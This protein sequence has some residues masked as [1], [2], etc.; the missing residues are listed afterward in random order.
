MKA[1]QKGF[2]LMDEISAE[3]DKLCTDENRPAY[4]PFDFFGEG[5]LQALRKYYPQFITRD[6]NEPTSRVPV[7]E[8]VATPEGDKGLGQVKLW[9]K[10]KVA[11]KKKGVYETTHP[12]AK[13]IGGSYGYW[14][15]KSWEK[16]GKWGDYSKSGT[17]LWRGT[18]KGQMSPLSRIEP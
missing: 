5:Y 10:I 3:F 1:P 17:M 11:P 13:N 4:V 14:N 6:M 16:Y 9:F 2:A 18:G 7:F 15:G 12:A 8:Q